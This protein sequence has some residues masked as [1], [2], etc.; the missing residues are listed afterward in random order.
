MVKLR[1]IAT[2]AR[3]TDHQPK[4]DAFRDFLNGNRPERVTGTFVIQFVHHPNFQEYSKTIEYY[5]YNDGSFDRSDNL[6]HGFRRANS[7]QNYRTPKGTGH[8]NGIFYELNLYTSDGR[9]AHHTSR[10][11]GSQYARDASH[12]VNPGAT[13]GKHWLED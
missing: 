4:F 12:D 13:K 2:G 10:V 8:A 1:A 11:H 6:P 7:Y 3:I 5:R 9:S